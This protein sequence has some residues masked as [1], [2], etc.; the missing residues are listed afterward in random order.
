MPLQFTYRELSQEDVC[1]IAH[2][3]DE[4]I[5]RLK[6]KIEILIASNECMTKNIQKTVD[7]LKNKAEEQNEKTK[8][9]K[10]RQLYVK[11]LKN[12]NTALKKSFQ[13]LLAG[14]RDEVVEKVITNYCPWNH[15]DDWDCLEDDTPYYYNK[16][17]DV[18]VCKTC[19]KTTTE[20][21][22]AF[23]LTE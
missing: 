1:D 4:E 5:K 6:R 20:G 15:C 23:K 2:K 16:K 13:S 22:T 9:R 12:E 21:K 7:I 18:F 19:Y 3:Q 14:D 10:E 8:T 17:Y 11:N